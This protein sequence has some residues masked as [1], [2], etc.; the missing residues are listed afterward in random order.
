MKYIIILAIAIL[1]LTFGCKEQ[2]TITT[3]GVTNATGKDLQNVTVNYNTKQVADFGK[4]NNNDTRSIEVK[5][6]APG[7]IWILVNGK[8]SVAVKATKISHEI[9]I[10]LENV[11]D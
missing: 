7:D 2:T 5:T 11:N 4:I 3:V 8:R 10:V 9:T 1:I 6:T